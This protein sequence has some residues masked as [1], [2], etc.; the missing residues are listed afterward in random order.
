MWLPLNQKTLCPFCI[1][2]TTMK[3]IMVSSL[4]VDDNSARI[5]SRLSVSKAACSVSEN[6]IGEKFDGLMSWH[7][8]E[9][10]V[11][12]CF[13]HGCCSQDYKWTGPWCP[14]GHGFPTSRVSSRHAPSQRVT[15]VPP[16]HKLGHIAEM[17]RTLERMCECVRKRDWDDVPRARLTDTCQAWGGPFLWASHVVLLFSR[18]LT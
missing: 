13:A 14:D 1:L 17:E 12:W 10:F 6:I 8:Y 11:Y 4:I 2:Q 7:Q 16:P 15:D 9:C 5:T 18:G 3:P